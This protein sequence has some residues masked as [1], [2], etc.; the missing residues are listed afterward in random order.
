FFDQQSHSCTDFEINLALKACISLN[1][2]QRGMN[3]RKKLSQN[4]LNNPYIQTTLIQFYMRSRDVNN[5]YHLFSTNTNKSN[6]IYATMFKGLISNNMPTKVLDLFDEMNI[7]SNQAILAALFSACSRV[8]NDR[9]MKIGRKLLNQIPKNFLND[10]KLLTSAINILMRFGD[11]SSVENLFQT[12]K[13]KDIVAY[14]AMMKGNLDIYKITCV[15][16]H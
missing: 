14:G 4:S 9:A 7:E 12:I 5:A 10:D 15:I 11:V 2:Y 6:Y 13:K 1:E 3:I 16:K 8:A